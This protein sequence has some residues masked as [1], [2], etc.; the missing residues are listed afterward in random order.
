[1]AKRQSGG[2]PEID[3]LGK[4]QPLADPVEE[5]SPNDQARGGYDVEDYHANGPVPVGHAP[6][7]PSEPNKSRQKGILEGATAS[8]R[9]AGN[10]GDVPNT[11]GTSR[12]DALAL[13]VKTTRKRK[14][15]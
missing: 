9:R 12:T 3:A 15:A 6:V 8:P 11:G 7:R 5:R 13:V 2:K 10:A 14:P 1:M 4:K